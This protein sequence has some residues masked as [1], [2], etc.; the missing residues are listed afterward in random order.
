MLG[1]QVAV[2]GQKLCVFLE[3]EGNDDK[4]DG[5]GDVMERDHGGG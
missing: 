1:P 5:M 2:H 4:A 3:E